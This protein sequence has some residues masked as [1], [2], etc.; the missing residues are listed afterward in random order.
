MHGARKQRHGDPLAEVRVVSHTDVTSGGYQAV[1]SKLRNRRGRASTYDCESCGN[2]AE[3]WAYDHND[4]AAQVAIVN[5]Y[6]LT[7]SQN[8]WHY[9]PLCRR[10]HTAFDSLMGDQRDAQAAALF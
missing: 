7:F 2:A 4:P 9:K 10:C 5:G 1:H 6:P 3:D 8:I